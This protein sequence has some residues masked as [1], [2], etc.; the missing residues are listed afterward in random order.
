MAPLDVTHRAITNPARVHAIRAP[1]G[2][3]ARAVA[4]ILDAY[5]SKAKFGGEGG[6]IHDACA[7]AWILRPEMM[8]GRTCNVRVD[9][10]DGP[11]RGRTLVDWWG[12]DRNGPANALVLDRI[13]D[14]AFFALLTERLARYAAD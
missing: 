1:G 7:V 11:S 6:P 8:S 9:T 14:E 5:P 12:G 3:V 4:G 10:G 2:P 13:D